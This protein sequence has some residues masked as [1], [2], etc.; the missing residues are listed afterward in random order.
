MGVW[1][2]SSVVVFTVLNIDKNSWSK[3]FFRVQKETVSLSNLH[4]HEDSIHWKLKCE[5]NGVVGEIP[6]YQ[7][8]SDVQ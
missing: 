6:V 2:S 1:Q 4:Q 8:N 5:K 7:T 3:V